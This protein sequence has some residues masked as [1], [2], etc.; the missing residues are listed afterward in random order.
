MARMAF[1]LPYYRLAPASATQLR[2]D[3]DVRMYHA[4]HQLHQAIPDRHGTTIV[5]VRKNGKVCIMGDGMVSQ[6]PVIVKP[7]VVKIRRILPKDRKVSGLKNLLK[8]SIFVFF[9]SC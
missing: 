6:G 7:N 2:P 8:F 9:C 5:C 1:S 4:T 3:D